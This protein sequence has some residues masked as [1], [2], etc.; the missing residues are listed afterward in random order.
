MTYQFKEYS[1]E[2]RHCCLVMDLLIDEGYL[3]TPIQ[4]NFKT[5]EAKS[6]IALRGPRLTERSRKYK[7]S[8]K[9]SYC[10][11]CGKK[12]ID[13]EPATPTEEHEAQS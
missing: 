11:G 7:P 8:L 6:F 2:A 3:E 9:L 5:G 10:P 12:L 4:L 1:G 13:D